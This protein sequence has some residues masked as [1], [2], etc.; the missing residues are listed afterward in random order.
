MRE[1]MNKSE[2]EPAPSVHHTK[3]DNKK[4]IPYADQLQKQPLKSKIIGSFTC[5]DYR[6]K[7]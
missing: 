1:M 3:D 4:H 7:L 5:S 6:E 2:K